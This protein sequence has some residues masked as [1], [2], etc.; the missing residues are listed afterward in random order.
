MYIDIFIDIY[1]QMCNEEREQKVGTRLYNHN[2]HL[3]HSKVFR[4]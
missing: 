4:S 3:L 1:R 2:N